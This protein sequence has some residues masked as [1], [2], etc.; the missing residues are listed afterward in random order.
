MPRRTICLVGAGNIRVAPH[1]IAALAEYFPDAE[2]EVRLFDSNE[3]RLDLIDRLARAIFEITKNEAIIK[4]S[5][6]L[7]E[8]LEGVTDVIIALNED[9]ARRM[10][11]R[12]LSHTVETVEASVGPMDVYGGDPNRPTP[13]EQ[14]SARM[15][16]MLQVADLPSGSREEAV[17]A[18]WSLV[19]MQ[20]PDSVK[21]RLNLTRNLEIE[22]SNWNWPAPLTE[23]EIQRQ[24]HRILRWINYDEPVGDLLEEGRTSALRR[25]IEGDDQVQP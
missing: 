23:T 8:A 15:K 11:G 2:Y 21:R 12:K 1:V 18:A 20:I 10:I 19:Q 7:D 4:S 22:G 9:G 17:T 25:W 6:D 13:T 14:L 16:S 5:S 24:P 3:E